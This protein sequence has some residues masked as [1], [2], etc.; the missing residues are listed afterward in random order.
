MRALVVLAAFS[1]LLVLAVMHPQVGLFAWGWLT[2]MQPHREVWGLGNANLNLIVAVVTIVIWLFSQEPKKPLGEPTT[3]LIILFMV[4]MG[5]CQLYSLRPEHSWYHFNQFIRV[6][7]FIYVSLVLIRTK[8]RIHAMVFVLC[9]SIGYYAVKGG[10]FTLLTGGAY[11]VVGPVMTIIG[12]RNH[13]G[14]AAVFILPLLNYLRMQTEARWIRI[15]FLFAIALTV[16]CVLGTH[17]RGALIALVLV[18]VPFWWR[19]RHRLMLAVVLL[20]LAFG[21]VSFM[22]EQW[23]ARMETIE[24]ADTDASFQG[25]IDAWVIAT[26]IALGNPLTGAGFRVAYLQDVADAYLSEPRQARA[27]HSIYFEILGSMGFVGLALF[28][29]IIALAFWNA[30]WIRHHT[31]DQ[32][33]LQWARDL[34]SMAQIS[35]IAYCIAGAALSLEFWEGP[36]LMFVILARLRHEIAAASIKS[37]SAVNNARKWY[38]EPLP[39]DSADGGGAAQGANIP[40][41]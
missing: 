7:V 12:D 8:A 27:A 11:H 33:G 35:L 29:S 28:M 20:P 41:C 5:V 40:R 22:P 38:M 10:V 16:V 36:W 1:G 25:R 14:G 37:K 18:A 4:W 13:L 26:K 34:A 23:S 39:H 24:T 17:S 19:S 21:A 15:L 30:S 3:V 31:K 2:L 9:I 6:M 32:V